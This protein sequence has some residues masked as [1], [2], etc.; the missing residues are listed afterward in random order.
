[1]KTKKI[2]NVLRW[3]KYGALVLV[4]LIWWGRFCH[5]MFR[6]S[7]EW[8]SPAVFLLFA[9]ALLAFVLWLVYRL[10]PRIDNLLF[11]FDRYLAV[12]LL[13]LCYAFYSYLD[14]YKDNFA[15]SIVSFAVY[16]FLTWI[17]VD[18]ER[19]IKAVEEIDSKIKLLR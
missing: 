7:Y 17:C 6:V 13:V 9:F 11:S 2:Y 1:M 14:F 15:Q 12:L 3:C 18:V 5:Y 8:F 4:V 19:S 16:Y 10:M